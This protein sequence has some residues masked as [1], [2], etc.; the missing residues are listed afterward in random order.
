MG[1]KE[2]YMENVAGKD[3]LSVDNNQSWSI[4]LFGFDKVK[5]M[6]K[7]NFYKRNAIYYMIY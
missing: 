3:S 4:S 6:I 2:G 7:T 5:S 1:G